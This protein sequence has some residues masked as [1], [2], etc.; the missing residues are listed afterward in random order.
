MCSK[1]IIITPERSHV[2]LPSDTCTHFCISDGKEFWAFWCFQGTQK[3]TLGRKG[4]RHISQNHSQE[5]ALSRIN[6]K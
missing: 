4:L 6:S 2:F 5:T 3:A 1:L